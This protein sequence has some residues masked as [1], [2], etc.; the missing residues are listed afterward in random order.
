MWHAAC[1]TNHNDNNL[2][3]IGRDNLDDSLM[4]VNDL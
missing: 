4:G 2:S 3:T 1:Y